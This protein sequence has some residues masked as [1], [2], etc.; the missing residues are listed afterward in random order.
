MPLPVLYLV[1]IIIATYTR[2]GRTTCPTDETG[3]TLVYEGIATGS[4]YNQYGGGAQYLCLPKAPEYWSFG[5]GISSVQ[6]Y[7]YGAEYHS[8][9]Y[10]SFYDHGA[11]CAVCL[12]AEKKDIL[13]IPAKTACP[14]SWTMEYSGFLVSEHFSSKSNKLFECVDLN[15]EKVPGTGGHQNSASFHHVRAL[16][17][18]L[19]CPPFIAAKDLACVVCSK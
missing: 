19:T 10:P 18:G 17:E 14:A 1:I 7:L 5:T 3:A 4:H 9:H 8:R 15:R 12:A 16:C 11:P 6:A 2:W 13:M